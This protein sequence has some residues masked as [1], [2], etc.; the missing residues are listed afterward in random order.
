VLFVICVLILIG[1]SM[2]TAPPPEYKIAG[3][4]YGTAE[5]DLI[6]PP[7]GDEARAARAEEEGAVKTRAEQREDR[8]Q[9]LELTERP[10]WRRQDLLLTVG[11]A[12]AVGLVWLLFSPIVF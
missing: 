4:T 3:L 7:A 8:E 12:I 10:E 6:A 2:A 1:V 11:V 9:P 5:Q